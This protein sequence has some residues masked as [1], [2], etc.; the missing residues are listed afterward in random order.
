MCWPQIDENT[1]TNRLTEVCCNEKKRIKFSLDDGTVSTVSHYYQY[2][3]QVEPKLK[4]GM[5]CDINKINAP[6]QI[7]TMKPIYK[8]ATN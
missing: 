8:F 7:Y 2:L 6:D 4:G 1:K 3:R 5:N